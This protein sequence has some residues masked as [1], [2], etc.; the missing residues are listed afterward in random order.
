MAARAEN[1]GASTRLFV[2]KPTK[3]IVV[4]LVIDMDKLYET[5]GFSG[6]KK[7]KTLSRYNKHDTA[8]MLV[9]LV[10]DLDMI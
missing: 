4:Q 3:E 9:Y 5:I 2:L 6:S 10:F 8:F 7:W 1:T